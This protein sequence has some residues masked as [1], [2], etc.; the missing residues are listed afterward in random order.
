MAWG[1]ARDIADFLMSLP[2]KEDEVVFDFIGGEPLLEIDLITKVSD[3]L[4]GSMEKLNHPWLKSYSFRFTTN[5]LAYSSAKVQEYVSKHREH[6]SVQI[7]IDGT[8][9]KHDLNRK[10]SDGRGSYDQLLPNVKL[11]LSQFGKDAVS[12]MVISHEDLPYLAESVIHLIELGVKE[13]ATNLV[14]ED[15]WKK[16]DAA[17][18]EEQLMLIADYVIANR[19]WETVTVSSLSSDIGKPMTDEHLFPCGNPMYVF[20]SNGNIYSCVRFVQFSLREKVTR[21]IGT[22]AKGIDSNKLRPLLSFD[23]ES[24]YPSRCLKCEIDTGCRWCPA[25]NYD[26]SKTGTIFMRTTTICDLH[27]ANVRVKNYFWNKIY[28]IEA[29]ERPKT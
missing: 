15:V 24:C 4:V 29:N 26:A 25:E 7:S 18:F 27:K 10:F 16:E 21:R 22:L 28:Y 23:K 3:Y 11:W 6:L 2:V 8:K 19:L 5:G 17:V 12:F 9:Q 13:I 1:T 20:D 14:V